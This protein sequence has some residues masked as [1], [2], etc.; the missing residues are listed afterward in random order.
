[1]AMDRYRYLHHL[2][3]LWVS[4][5]WLAVLPNERPAPR[6]SLQLLRWQCLVVYAATGLSKLDRSWLDGRE[7]QVLAQEGLVQSSVVRQAL[8]LVGT[9]AAAL[10]VL[11]VELGLVPLLMVRRTRLVAVAVGALFHLALSASMAVSIFGALMALYLVQFLP[12]NE[13]RSEV[14]IGAGDH[15]G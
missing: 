15:S 13:S 6:Y 14:A 8:D 2:H 4:V 10:G 3:L 11:L 7:L 9:R 12:W 5:A 1:M